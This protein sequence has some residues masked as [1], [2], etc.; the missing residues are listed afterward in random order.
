MVI[1]FPIWMLFFS[2]KDAS[3]WGSFF[4]PTNFWMKQTGVHISDVASIGLSRTS[5]KDFAINLNCSLRIVLEL[6]ELTSSNMDR[7]VTSSCLNAYGNTIGVVRPDSCLQS[8]QKHINLFVLQRERHLTLSTSQSFFG[9]CRELPMY[10]Q[11]LY[12]ESCLGCVYM[13]PFLAESASLH[14]HSLSAHKCFCV[15]LWLYVKNQDSWA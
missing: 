11:Q 1:P 8:W 10:P 15:I 6:I 2:L 5:S 4:P 14:W 9:C 3:H 13:Y 7:E 12:S